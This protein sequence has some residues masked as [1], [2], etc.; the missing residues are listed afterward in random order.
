MIVTKVGALR[1]AATV[2]PSCEETEPMTP[3]MGAVI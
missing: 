2:S 3:G 1:P